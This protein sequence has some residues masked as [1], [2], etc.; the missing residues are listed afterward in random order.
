[1][2]EVIILMISRPLKIPDT[3]QIRVCPSATACKASFDGPTY[4]VLCLGFTRW[5]NRSDGLH[6]L[7]TGEWGHQSIL[8]RIETTILDEFATVITIHYRR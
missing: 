5:G 2:Q 1:M 4:S 6:F 7:S 8:K 3:R